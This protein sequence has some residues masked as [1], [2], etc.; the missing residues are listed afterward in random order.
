MR[1]V[2]LAMLAAL[3]ALSGALHAGEFRSIGDKAAV[4][5]D[6]PSS[7]AN[8]RYVLTQG[9]PVEVVVVVEGWTKVR[10]A[11]GEL[12]WVETKH[13]AE[14]RFLLVNVPVA[15]IRESAEDGAPVAFEA[16]ENVLLELLEVVRGG[17]LR[18]RH[19]D[20]QEG[21]V[22]VTQIWGA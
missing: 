6:A 16:E 22:K 18:V 19:R 21:F 2:T 15:Q 12:T 14:K 3:V 10:D 7:K 17:W 20:G 8:K 5:Y 4:L 1:P 13:L 11:K 9:Y